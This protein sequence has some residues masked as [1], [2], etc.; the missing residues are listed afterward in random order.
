[1]TDPNKKDMAIARSIRALSA[2]AR[3]NSF[4]FVR[5]TNKLTTPP[6]AEAHKAAVESVCDAMD[7]LA[8]EAL[9]RKVAYSEF[10]A[11]RKQLIK[12]N[13]FPPNEYFEPVA[14]AFAENGG[15]Q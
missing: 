10:D 2:Y 15:L 9:E 6:Q 8:N 1:M 14:R 7:A 4:V 5:P 13:S 3:N 12:L 11:L